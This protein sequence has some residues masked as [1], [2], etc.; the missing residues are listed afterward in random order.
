MVIAFIKISHVM[1]TEFLSPV[2]WNDKELLIQQINTK[3]WNA[4]FRFYRFS[5]ENINIHKDIQT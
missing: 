4:L 3:K 1:E 2:F 5:F